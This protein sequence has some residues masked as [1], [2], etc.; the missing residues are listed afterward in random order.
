MKKLLLSIIV[1]GLYASTTCEK[2]VTSEQMS[3]DQLKAMLLEK[4]QGKI[5]G[6]DSI[7]RAVTDISGIVGGATAKQKIDT[8][9]NQLI[10]MGSIDLDRVEA[11]IEKVLH[12]T[13]TNI[14]KQSIDLADRTYV[15]EV[16]DQLFAISPWNK[17]I[18]WSPD[19]T[20]VLMLTW[21]PAA[22]KGT[23]E[24]C[25]N[26]GELMNISWDAWVTA[27]PEVKDK[28]REYSQ[29]RNGFGLTDRTEQLLGLIPSKPPYAVTQNK[30]FVEMW[31]R[32]QDVFRPCLD[33]E[34]ID[35]SCMIDP[36]ESDLDSLP[37]VY[38]DMSQLVAM[39]PEHKAWFE[40]EKKSKYT[41]QWAMP[42]TRF[43]YTYD[44]G[45]LKKAAGKR[46][47]YGASEYLLK[48]GSN[49]LIH[50]IIPTDNYPNIP[51]PTSGY[52]ARD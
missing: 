8:A 14:F 26:S 25:L 38:R 28:L 12:E 51:T 15:H 17:K 37:P 11:D 52:I 50:S 45:S 5:N 18:V 35:S 2:I 44:W 47:A 29:N 1:V 9:V 16:S 4:Y 7:S 36:H 3:P 40:N 27:V 19:Q 34:T 23:Y 42:W 32:P 33:A 21:I 39:T 31:V 49:V 30:L 24:K 48:R 22:Y 13:L 43:G 10:G 46:A 20:R 6:I 41:G